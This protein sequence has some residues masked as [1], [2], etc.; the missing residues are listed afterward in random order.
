MRIFEGG[1]ALVTGAGSGIGR[2]T[3]ALFAERGARVTCV[4]RDA[5]TCEAAA[6]AIRQAGGEALALALDVADAAAGLEAVRRTTER[7]GRLDHAFN[8]AG[9]RGSWASPWDEDQILGVISVNLLG[10]MWGMK[11]QVAH[12]SANGGGTIVNTS[13]IAGIS[14]NV[15]AMDYTA[16]KHGVVGLTKAAAIRYG[17]KGVRINAVCPG[18]IETGMSAPPGP[19]SPEAEATLRRLSPILHR[20]GEARDVA[21]AV[22]WL[23]SP[24]SKFVFGVALPVD[25]GFSIN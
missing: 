11:H 10:V 9:V 7:F 18:L 23:S 17:A 16:A 14:G 21:E 20:N 25:G 2:A 4:D 24:L 22:T 5:G 1:V 6:E 12:M 15:G 3:A 8:N 19:Q 13:S